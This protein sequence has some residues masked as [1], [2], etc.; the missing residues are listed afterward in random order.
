MELMLSI[1][2][3]GF[4]L[5]KVLGSSRHQVFYSLDL[6]N[7]S[8]AR[9]PPWNQAWG[10][11]PWMKVLLPCTFGLGNRSWLWFVPMHPT[12]VQSSHPFLESLKRV[13][14][15]APSGDSIA[16]LEDFNTCVGNDSKTWGDDWE[17]RTAYLHIWSSSKVAPL[18]LIN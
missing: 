12:A 4:S 17:E 9:I 16:L 2:G 6:L 15:S 3:T 14:E 5:S 18:E 11:G 13:L 7:S 1:I 10:S 8:D